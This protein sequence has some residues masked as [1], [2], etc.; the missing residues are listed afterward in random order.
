VAW[1]DDLD[2]GRLTGIKPFRDPQ[3]RLRFER[4]QL[5]QWSADAVASGLRDPI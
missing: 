3:I 4:A 2:T 1:A 5:H